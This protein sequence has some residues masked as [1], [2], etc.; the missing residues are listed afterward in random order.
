MKIIVEDI[1][2]EILGNSG[3]F[4]FEY[5]LDSERGGDILVTLGDTSCL[6]LTRN[7]CGGKV[8]NWSN[9]ETKDSGS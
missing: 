5:E 6:F 4:Y 8:S 2:F 9:A 1:S 7:Q 3:N